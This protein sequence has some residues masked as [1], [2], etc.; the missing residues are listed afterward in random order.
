[1]AKNL[2][3][4]GEN[5]ARVKNIYIPSHLMNSMV[6]LRPHGVKVRMIFLGVSFFSLQSEE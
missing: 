2:R 4:N 5:Q 6:F 3:R 1:M